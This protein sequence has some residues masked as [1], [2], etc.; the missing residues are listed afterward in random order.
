MSQARHSTDR[1]DRASSHPAVSRRLDFSADD[2]SLSVAQSPLRQPARRG[3]GR[4]RK[5]LYRLTASPSSPAVRNQERDIMEEEDEDT[6]APEETVE[7]TMDTEEATEMPTN[8]NY[9]DDEPIMDDSMQLLDE[10]AEQLPPSSPS[11]LR[12][13]RYHPAEPETTLEPEAGEETS[14]TLRRG[15][16]MRNSL[17][18][19]DSLLSPAIVAK[20]PPAKKAP[21]QKKAPGPGRGRKGK[22]N[23]LV[24]SSVRP[25]EDSFASPELPEEAEEPTVLEES[26]DD[27]PIEQPVPARKK[28]RPAKAAPIETPD[29]SIAEAA[30]PPKKRGR[31][32]KPL[33]QTRAESPAEQ[34][35]TK[36]R[37]RPARKVDES[38]I[39]AAVSAADDSAA[40]PAQKKKRGR[41]GR[42]EEESSRPA[43]KAKTSAKKSTAN[44][45]KRD[46]PALKKPAAHPASDS[47]SKRYARA[48]SVVG[49]TTA[50]GRSYMRLRDATPFETDCFIKTR[51]GRSVVPVI[52]TWLGE[53]IEY[54]RDGAKVTIKKA[55]KVDVP[56]IERA[57]TVSAAPRK[58]RKAAVSMDV[59]EE[60][61]GQTLEDW[62]AR[63]DTI[64][65]IV[66]GWDPV[67]AL[68]TDEEEEVTV[69]YGVNSLP[70][71]MVGGGA[72]FAF[73]K[74]HSSHFFGT[75]IMEIPPGGYKM[76]KNSRKMTMAFFMHTGK[77]DVMVAE[78]EFTISKGG[79]F[80]VPRGNVYAIHNHGDYP[81]RIFFS[82]GCQVPVDVDE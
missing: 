34:I 58:Q 21:L 13:S 7:P 62:E 48:S 56:K 10:E 76:K 81:A 22:S 82:Q 78:E 30:P 74:T 27:T 26:D 38:I 77:V 39:E 31:A 41:P 75:G 59:I 51:S 47:P 20:Q 79:I 64:K 53:K 40:E 49:T 32:P 66:Q 11:V 73:T 72:K 25:V 6:M 80:H 3:N 23:L 57:R 63:K 18:N 19:G 4:P 69:A 54:G 33:V 16:R 37:G 9:E 70:I 68:T 12:K 1:D 42:V 15:G 8:G 35:K 2:T 29:E 28:G 46:P 5:D 61:E 45:S 55:E 71:E 44:S 24:S 52:E 14:I 17:E 50:G 67:N 60:E 65:A 36:K 43:K